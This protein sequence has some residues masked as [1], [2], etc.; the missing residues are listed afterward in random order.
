MSAG[1]LTGLPLPK[2]RKALRNPEN[3]FFQFV[4]PSVSSLDFWPI[5]GMEVAPEK[6]FLKVK[7]K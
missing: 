2:K 6:C 1:V 7:K 5:S 4:K 3:A